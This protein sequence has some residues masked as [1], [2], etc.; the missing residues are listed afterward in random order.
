MGALRLHSSDRTSENS[1]KLV[2]DEYYVRMHGDFGQ[3][4]HSNALLLNAPKGKGNKAK[5]GKEDQVHHN[6]LHVPEQCE[7]RESR[8]MNPLASP[9]VSLDSMSPDKNISYIRSCDANTFK[10]S[11]PEDV[12]LPRMMLCLAHNGK[13][14]WDVK[15]RPVKEY[16]PASMSVMGYLAVLLGNG[17][18]EV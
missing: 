4:E 8:L 2:C 3:T 17:A 18:L 16:D 11:I 7:H 9:S 5:A 10:K 13:V 15:W 6:G 1:S 14:A 12:A